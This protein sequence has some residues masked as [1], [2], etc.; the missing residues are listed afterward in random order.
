MME[1]QSP[2]LGTD[3]LNCTLHF[4][5]GRRDKKFCCAKCRSAYHNR[6]I[7]QELSPVESISKALEKNHQVLV[8]VKASRIS[9]DAIAKNI[10]VYEGYQFSLST[11]QTINNRTDGIIYWIC[12]LGLEKNSDGTYTIHSKRIEP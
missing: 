10:L 12:D 2:Y 6:T 8:K 7:G 3:C 1:N 9:G 5:H 4:R 11:E